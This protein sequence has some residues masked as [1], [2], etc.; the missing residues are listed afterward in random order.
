VQPS[1]DEVAVAA[2]LHAR[3]NDCSDRGRPAEAHALLREALVVLGEPEDPRARPGGTRA[4]AAAPD[5]PEAAAV[6]ARVLVSLAAQG[7]VLDADERLSER[8]LARALDLAEAAGAHD[9]ALTVHGQRGLRALRAGDADA[10]VVH[11]DAGVALIG[12]ATP[13][14]A[15]IL[16]LNRG[17]LHLER[18]DLDAAVRDLARCADGAQA[19]GDPMLVFKARHNLGYAEFLAGRLPE[20]L[21]AMQDA[22]EHLLPVL[23]EDLTTM[24]VA[25]LDRAQ[26]LFEVGLLTE[27][28]AMLAQAA[29]S[30]AARGLAQDLGEVEVLRARCARLLGRLEDARA[31]ARG[32][33]ERFGARGSVTWVERA[34]LVELRARLDL[35][36][37]ADGGAAAELRA[38]RDEALAL[39][40]PARGRPQ[41]RVAALVVA[42]E[43]CARLGEHATAR[44]LVA[45]AVRSRWGRA[46]DIRTSVAV[47]RARCAFAE[48]DV[49]AGVRAVVAGQAALAEHRA[50]LGSVEALV[51]SGVFGERLADL[52]VAAAAATGDPHRVLDA[53]ERARTL[54][55]GL[56]SVRPADGTARLAV[57]LRRASEELRLAEP[58]GT[59]AQVARLHDRTEELRGRLRA[60]GWRARG[61]GAAVAA[62]RAADV[63]RRLR[64]RDGALAEVVVVGDELLATV[65]D[66]AGARLVRLGPAEPV[67]EASSRLRADLRV[68]ARPGLPPAM[69]AVVEASAVRQAALVDERLVR[70]LGVD[71]PLHVVG[72]AWCVTLPWAAVPSRRGRATSAGPRTGLPAPDER[73]RA[74]AGVVVVAGPDLPDAEL[75]AARV[76]ARWP[77]ATLLAGGEATCAAVTDALRAADVVH[78]AAHGTHVADNPLF[79]SVRLADGPLLAHEIAT[80]PLVART[81]VLAACEVGAATERAGGLPLGLASV[82][83]GLGARHVVGAV[84]TV[85]DGAA[86]ATMTRFHEALT[87]DGGPGGAGAR[88]PA[89]LARA[90]AEVPFSPFVALTTS[91]PV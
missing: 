60:E 56:A 41:A 19:A 32:A 4:G 75:E 13:R 25:L 79:S 51:A 2:E 7:D 62:T 90:T 10:A 80:E 86:R 64:G 50:Q 77:G 9:V 59:P 16:L 34:R 81:V 54:L 84:A 18:G 33:R 66:G 47:V 15:G 27:A 49:A 43:A 38:V 23:G 70:P 31:L 39:A 69:R 72:P 11:L 22:A 45:R 46:I 14:D 28:D 61:A 68:L 78:L 48:G 36:R 8:R 52:D 55:A 3:A 6:L 42:A 12:H 83:L 30:F 40:G 29:E 88:V 63:V 26:V 91:L 17:T 58:S 82:L 89:A 74:G 35:V 73:R 44:G 57:E 87:G 76:A 5:A 24:P 37:D 53:A 20:A 65:V 85:G 21:D 71:G 1:T 67:V